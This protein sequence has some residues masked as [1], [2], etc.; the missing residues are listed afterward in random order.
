[1]SHLRIWRRVIAEGHEAAVALEDDVVLFP[2]FNQNLAGLLADLPPDWDVC[3]LGAVGCIQQDVEPLHMKLYALATGGSRASPGKTRSI[4]EKLYVPCKPAGTHAYMVSQRGAKKLA[5]AV[6]KARYHVDLTAW[7]L[8][9]LNLYAAKGFLATQRFGDD[10]TVSKESASKTQRYL[11]WLVRCTGLN[12]MCKAGGLPNLSWTWKTALVAL[13]VPFTSPMRKLV[14]DLGPVTCV[15][16]I[17]TLLS[18]WTRNMKLLGLAMLWFNLISFTIRGL[19]G[20]LSKKSVAVLMS[21]AC[22]CFLVPS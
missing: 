16:I 6:P 19:A 2:N 1:M 18:A 20:T 14:V 9:D 7:S 17:L 15:W 11:A 3:L 21:V 22:A 8:Q 5:E 13:P 10:T 12:A 4:S